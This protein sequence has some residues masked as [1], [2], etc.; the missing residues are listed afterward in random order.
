M[1]ITSA[2]FVAKAAIEHARKVVDVLQ[3]NHAEDKV[4]IFDLTFLK[5]VESVAP[6]LPGV[7]AFILATDHQH[8]PEASSIPNLYCYEDL[9]KQQQQHLPFHWTAK[10]ET[11]PCGACYT[12]GTTGRPKV[13]PPRHSPKAS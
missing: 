2:G 4:I 9:L 11:A 1:R 3:A 12:S 6:K 10:D 8:M 13:L 7:K 5:L